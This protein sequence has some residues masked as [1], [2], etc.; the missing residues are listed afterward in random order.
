MTKNKCVDCKEYLDLGGSH[1]CK[2]LEAYLD[3]GFATKP[4][5]CEE[6]DKED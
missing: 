1:F 6:F 4:K 2:V 5:D 3:H